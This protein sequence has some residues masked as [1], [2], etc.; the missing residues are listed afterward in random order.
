MST[1]RLLLATE[2]SYLSHYAARRRAGAG[3]REVLTFEVDGER[4]AIDIL[5]LREIARF[6]PVTEVP[7][8]P[9]GVLGILALRGQVV[10][11]LD[12]RIKLGRTTPPGGPAPTSR[13]LVA[14]LDGEPVGLAVDRVIGVVRLAATDIEPKTAALPIDLACISAIARVGDDL[15]ALVDVDAV[16]HLEWPEPR[17][18]AGQRDDPR[19]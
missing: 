15:F 17:L 9:A 2:A 18:G 16:A 12:L 5:R 13:I 11:V 14:D 6:R 3:D 8:V 19:S 10:P 4:F 7:R 1:P